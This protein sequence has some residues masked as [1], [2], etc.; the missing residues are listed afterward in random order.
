MLKNIINTKKISLNFVLIR[1]FPHIWIYILW[2]T[3]HTRKCQQQDGFILHKNNSLLSN[4]Y[5][6]NIS[7]VYNPDKNSSL[8]SQTI[9]YHMLSDTKSDIYFMIFGYVPGLYI[10]YSRMCKF[11]TYFKYRKLLESNLIWFPI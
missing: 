3:N 10:F 9:C 6:S 4:Q 11:S 1:T 2:S 7:N 8:V 5:I